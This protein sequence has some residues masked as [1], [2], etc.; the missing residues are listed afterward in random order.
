MRGFYSKQL[1]EKSF[2][3]FSLTLATSKQSELD[4]YA[5]Y[6]VTGCITCDAGSDLGFL[7]EPLRHGAPCF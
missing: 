6:R 3:M 4:T 7:P 2:S 5:S 1:V